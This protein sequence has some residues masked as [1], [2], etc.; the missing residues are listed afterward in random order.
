MSRQC[1]GWVLTVVRGGNACWFGQDSLVGAGQQ[2]A[3]VILKKNMKKF[4]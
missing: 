3:Y 1:P 4:H 2:L